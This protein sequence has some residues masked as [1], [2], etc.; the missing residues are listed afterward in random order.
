MR[1]CAWR[2]LLEFEIDRLP[3]DLLQITRN[4]GIRVVRNSSIN[5]LLPYEK[6]KSFFDGQDWVIVYNDRL[7]T[8][9][10][11]CTVAHELGH[12]FLGHE[13]TAIKYARYDAFE[14]SAK[15][16]EQADQFAYRL[17]CPAC[18]LWGLDLHTAEEIAEV[19]HVE[20]SV[21]ERR[22]KRM[23]QLYERN[24]FLT[25]P[26]EKQVYERFDPFIQDYFRHGAPNSEPL[27]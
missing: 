5:V 20:R 22:A 26:L 25:L 27:E 1:D 6:G 8:P 10:I 9:M 15:S 19:C 11:R 17:L 14:R 13:M 21:A 23:K 3:V 24:R 2:C 12:I 7:P 16:E 4:A 18:V